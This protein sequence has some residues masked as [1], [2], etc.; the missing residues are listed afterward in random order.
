[1]EKINLVTDETRIE[2][3]FLKS[4]WDGRLG[5]SGGERAA[6]QTLREV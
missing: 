5:K 4:F 1:M 3:G 2:R 6:V